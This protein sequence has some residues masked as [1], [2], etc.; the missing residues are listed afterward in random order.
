MS[1]FIRPPLYEYTKLVDE[2]NNLR[3]SNGMDQ[4]VKIR[5]GL[6]SAD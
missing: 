2:I 4:V 3:Y 6:R 1:D 5:Q